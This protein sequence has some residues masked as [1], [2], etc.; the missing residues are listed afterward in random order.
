MFF[1]FF[2]LKSKKK[3]NT[4]ERL[5]CTMEAT[6]TAVNPTIQFWQAL[7]SFIQAWPHLCMYVCLVGKSSYFPPKTFWGLLHSQHTLFARE[8]QQSFLINSVEL[9]NRMFRPCL[10]AKPA[11]MFISPFSESAPGQWNQRG[12]G[13][14][15]WPDP[16][17]LSSLITQL[18]SLECTLLHLSILIRPIQPSVITTA[19][20]QT[21]STPTPTPL[22]PISILHPPAL[23][24]ST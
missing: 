13:E 6:E 10:W 24:F 7:M 12:E 9:D 19:H 15:S 21:D 4:N 2:F 18:L 3:K 14:S 1:L 16:E 23:S 5:H 20:R 11:E 8:L 22:P 17:Q